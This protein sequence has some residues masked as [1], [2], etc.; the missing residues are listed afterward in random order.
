MICLTSDVHHM[1]LCTRDQQCIVDTTEGEVAVKFLQGCAEKNISS[2]CFMTGRFVAEEFDCAK[3]I[4]ELPGIEIGG[5]TW[6][7]FQPEILH[8]VFNKLLGSFNGPRWYQ[9]RDISRTKQSLSRIVDTPITSWRNH[10][11]INDSNTLELLSEAGIR[12]LSDGT[13]S[14]Q[15]HP[16]MSD[17]GTRTFPINCIPDHEHL[18]HG[19][20]T[21]EYVD[22]WRKRTGF[23]DAFTAQSY[24]F[25]AWFNILEKQI[26]GREQRAETSVVLIHP[27]CI[28]L[29]GGEGA[30]QS[31]TDL[32]AEYQTCTL[33][34]TLTDPSHAEEATR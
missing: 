23:N 32:I 29:A 20:R 33:S 3:Q 25:D 2:T 34:S 19:K 24:D 6:S 31:V 8:R 7:A 26:R 12:I 22:K 4:A 16:L 14:D 13:S 9:R 11:Y 15:V 5:H 30:I 17:S 10:A 28:W 1:S 18:F 21:P 27:I